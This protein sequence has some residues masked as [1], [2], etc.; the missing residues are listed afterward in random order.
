MVSRGL[1]AIL[2]ITL[3][4]SAVIATL[5]SPLAAGGARVYKFEQ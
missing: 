5:F 4:K 1:F 3:K 2:K